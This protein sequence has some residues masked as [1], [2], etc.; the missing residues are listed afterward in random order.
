SRE[1]R[2]ELAVIEVEHLNRERVDTLFDPRIYPDP[3][4]EVAREGFPEMSPEEFV[5]MFCEHSRCEPSEE[6]TRIGFKYVDVE[7][8]PGPV[9]KAPPGMKQH[10]AALWRNG[11]AAP[12]D[13]RSDLRAW[14]GI[15]VPIEELKRR[16]AEE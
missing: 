16:P 5:E 3:R 1:E 13:L 8:P 15:D 12:D 6:V 11:L 9:P 10:Y 4:A 2:V 7:L 14:G